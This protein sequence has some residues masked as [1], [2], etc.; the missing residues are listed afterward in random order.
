M[1][2]PPF[3]ERPVTDRPQ[4]LVDAAREWM[5]RGITAADWQ[6]GRLVRDAQVR[7]AQDVEPWGPLV[8]HIGIA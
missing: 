2:C 6:V 1:S 3:V 5:V 7:D 8:S 4:P